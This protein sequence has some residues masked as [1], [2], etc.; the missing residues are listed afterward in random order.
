MTAVQV[1]HEIES[2][3]PQERQAVI[4]FITQM[5][6]PPTPAIPKVKTMVPDAFEKMSDQVFDQHPELFRKLAK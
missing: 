5:R 2:L 3:P 1:I 6:V 4:D